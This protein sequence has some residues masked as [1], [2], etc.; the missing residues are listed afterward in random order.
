MYICKMAKKNT[1]LYLDEDT[2]Q[3]AKK[4]DI[5]L[6]ELAAN[7]IK[8]AVMLK[9][10]YQDADKIIDNAEHHYIPIHVDTISVEKL[11][12]VQHLEADFEQV[13]VIVGPNASGKTLIINKLH[14]ALSRQ[15]QSNYPEQRSETATFQKCCTIAK[16]TK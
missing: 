4:L 3:E 1:L 11:G 13:N 5:N 16:K 7:A 8:R 10:A 14:E 2:V 9:Q 6:S 15:G 12:P